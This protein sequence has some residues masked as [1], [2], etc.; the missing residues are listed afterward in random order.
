MKKAMAF[1]LVAT[2]MMVFCNYGMA[3]AASDKTAARTSF[4]QLVQGDPLYRTDDGASTYRF[5]N[6]GRSLVM[7]GYTYTYVEEVDSSHAIYRYSPSQY[8]GV[9]V[10]ADG[11]T[12]KM[13]PSS[14]YHAIQWNSLGWKARLVE[15]Q[16]MGFAQ[17]VQGMKF[18]VRDLDT[19]GLLGNDLFTCEFDDDGSHAL[20]YQWK[21][22]SSDPVASS[23]VSVENTQSPN[24]GKVGELAVQLDTEETPWLLTVNG[25]TYIE[26]YSDPGPAFLNRVKGSTFTKGATTY[27]FSADGRTLTLT[28]VGRG[29]RA[30]NTYYYQMSSAPTTAYYSGWLLKLSASDTKIQCAT[31]NGVAEDLAVWGYTA[32]R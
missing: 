1:L 14:G 26:N 3:R 27:A 23:E 11:R 32:H 18:S 16:G 31:V 5:S 22:N 21:W 30:T 15:K 20:L 25:R 13:T 24:S 28:F 8:Y 9:F 4:L 7:D 29:G 6:N 12:A 19:A 2:G 10:S 17:L